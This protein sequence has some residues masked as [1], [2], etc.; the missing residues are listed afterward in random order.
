MISEISGVPLPKM[1]LPDF[2]T[3]FNAR[4]LTLVANVIKKPPLWGMAIDQ[5]RTM[6]EGVQ[7][8]GS[9]AERELG[10]SYTP[11]RVALEEAIASHRIG[12]GNS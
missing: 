8:D 2:M 7:V 10:I 11:I 4:F 12:R 3:L 1:R 5:I 9:K 6:K